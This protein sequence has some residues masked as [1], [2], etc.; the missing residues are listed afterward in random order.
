[1]LENG[2]EPK[3]LKDTAHIWSTQ[4]TRK[5]MSSFGALFVCCHLQNDAGCGVGRR[6]FVWVYIIRHAS[7][8]LFEMRPSRYIYMYVYISC[9]SRAC[10]Y[11]YARPSF[12][13]SIFIPIFR[14]DVFFCPLSLSLSVVLDIIH[15]N[16]CIYFER[17]PHATWNDFFAVCFVAHNSSRVCVCVGTFFSGIILTLSL[18]QNPL[19]IFIRF[20]ILFPLF[21]QCVCVCFPS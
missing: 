13:I 14:S 21:I 4:N 10:V 20:I 7:G 6:I 9:Y 17:L 19:L 15:I 16:T 2:K 5:S 8:L 11:R 3:Y 18:F 12:T 1:M